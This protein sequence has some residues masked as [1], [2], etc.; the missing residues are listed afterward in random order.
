V[1]KTPI[2]V[3]DLHLEISPD[4]TDVPPP[5]RPEPAGD[6]PAARWPAGVA[7]ALG[8]VVGAL[9]IVL[10][11][12]E[13][14]TST[15]S[16]HFLVFWSGIAVVLIPTVLLGTRKWVSVRMSLV[17]LVGFGLI[18]FLP[19]F[20]MSVNGPVYHDEFGHLRHANDLLTN[21]NLFNPLPYLPIVK[22]F[23]GLSALTVGVHE[24]TRLS[25]WHSGQLVVLV[26]HCG[27]LVVM[28]QLSRSAGL[29][30]R[31]SFVA[32]MT[33]SLNPSYMY[34]DT[35]YSYESLA[36][37]LAMFVLLAC[38]RA[39]QA[40]TR[41]GIVAWL[42]TGV[43]A[44]LMCIASHHL[45]SVFM[46][47]SCL[48]ILLLVRVE[49]RPVRVGI[50]TPLRAAW[51]IAGTAVVGT[52]IWLSA[53]ATTF[54]SYVWPHI[55][56]GFTE[57]ADLF[58]S[59]PKTVKGPGGVLLSGT[60]SLFSGSDVPIY[61]KAAA[62]AGPLIVL[63]VL[64]AAGWAF[65]RNRGVSFGRE[66]ARVDP[67]PDPGPFDAVAL[68]GAVAV[69]S[70]PPVPEEPGPEPEPGDVEHRP[71]VRTPMGPRLRL[72]AFVLAIGYLASLP[73]AL[74]SAGGE[75][76]HR[77][78]AYTYIGVAIVA[79]IVVDQH[80][81]L[82]APLAGVRSGLGPALLCAVLMVL[83]VGNVSAGED[84]SYRFPGPYQFGTDTRSVTPELTDLVQWLRTHVPPGT[85]VVTDRFTGEQ[86]EGYTT[87]NPPA[88][89][90]Y[91]VFALYREGE[92]PN[93]YLLKELRNGNFRYFIL[94]TRIERDLPQVAF[95][96][97]YDSAGSV[98][99]EA[100]KQMKGNWF[101][102]PVHRTPNFEVFELHP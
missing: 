3:P 75:G 66:D 82:T 17:L 53:V 13:A 42:T 47:G 20:L 31:G 96:E 62:F 57:L 69:P 6:H 50:L 67:D 70:G 21:G 88:P 41:R 76:A 28:Y 27:A 73:I 65:F 100:M 87:L 84:V 48:A 98:N 4:V 92:K 38:A 36:L 95:Y 83:C 5:S 85:K 49:P 24:V 18:T 79:G 59:N 61:E 9:L 102:T 1:V 71:I 14:R 12:R 19:K 8:Y 11:Y 7:V 81:R 32:A 26:A 43:A 30:Q 51:V 64:V 78:W 74:T 54:A 2:P 46:A 60:H 52:T 22:Y 45:S 34:F 80:P 15:G 40:S 35:Q 86:L 90:D 55:G 68:L 89:G 94:D 33:Y 56:P 99:V 72:F 25:L 93:G 16:G 10:A 39:A 77:S 23:P 37:P 101:A 58:R 63:T 29:T 44:A 91:E 97:G